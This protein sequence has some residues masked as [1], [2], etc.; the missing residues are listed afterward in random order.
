MK[1]NRII[2]NIK[3]EKIRF[4]KILFLTILIILFLNL[5]QTSGFSQQVVVKFYVFS[6]PECEYCE[7][8]ENEYLPKMF[9]KYEQKIEVKI[10]DVLNQEEYLL[11]NRFSEKLNYSD[12]LL[13]TVVVD[14][15]MLSGLDE[16]E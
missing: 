9:E 13:P 14:D 8:F 4:I 2:A 15:V 7:E 1:N 5:I 11:W 10:L 16:I 6:S 12:P 3:F